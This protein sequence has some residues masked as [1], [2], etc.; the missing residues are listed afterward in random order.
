MK[1]RTLL[2][3]GAT[4]GGAAMIGTNAF[5]SVRAER[6]IE[7]EVVGDQNALLALEPSD[8]E[9][10]VESSDETGNDGSEEAPKASE[11]VYETSDGT[12]VIDL[13]AVEDEDEEDERDGI[14]GEGITE[15]SLWRFPN[16]F[17]ITN[18]GAQNV[19]VDLKL[20]DD[21][22]EV[23][24]VDEEGDINGEEIE[25]GDPAVVFYKGSDSDEQFSSDELNPDAEGAVHLEPGDSVCVGFDVR[26]FGL[27]DDDLGGLT[28]RIRAEASDESES[29]A[30]GDL[31]NDFVFRKPRGNSVTSSSQE[32]N[33]QSIDK[34]T[35]GKN[36]V[37]NPTGSEGN[38]K[39]LGPP[40]YPSDGDL[41]APFLK[42][43]DKIETTGD[44][45]FKGLDPKAT[46]EPTL[47]AVGEFDGSPASIF[48]AGE[49]GEINRVSGGE[50]ENPVSVSD[51]TDAKA[52]AVAGIGDIDGDGADELVFVDEDEKVKYLTEG[53][54]VENTEISIGSTNSIGQPAAFGDD[55]KIPIVNGD[56]EIKLIEYDD[57]SFQT[58]PVTGA[59][60]AAQAPLTAIDLDGDGDLE[61]VYVGMPEDSEDSPGNSGNAPGN[62]GNAP[63]KLKFIDN[64]LSDPTIED[65]SGDEIHASSNTGVA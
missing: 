6:S 36:E 57:G 12:I 58:E 45:E 63:G 29:S 7:V 47:L 40:A 1:R 31:R 26:T 56:D 34:L 5:S 10:E 64:P 3:L 35:G 39:A 49:D 50:D 46:D 22:E 30:G 33:S 9:D 25:E 60:D 42:N 65:D 24:T 41:V 19:A 20:E 11:F 44:E 61:I 8:T 16:A 55:I 54:D 15:D 14:A 38:V 51:D 18:Q 32:G 23:P 43:K 27:K 52:V 21:N 4:L 53:G 62:S 37:T 28:L 48:Y 13:T 17:R 2:G 59:D